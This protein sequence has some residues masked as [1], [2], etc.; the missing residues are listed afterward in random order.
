MEH[1]SPVKKRIVIRHLASSLC[2][3]SLPSHLILT[4]NQPTMSSFHTTNA[5]SSSVPGH[6]V[7]AGGN[8]RAAVA[9]D[10]GTNVAVS[11]DP[12]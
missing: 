1:P 7:N 8:G 11:T 9:V 2:P 4:T 5:T 6:A 3:N 12:L 10:G